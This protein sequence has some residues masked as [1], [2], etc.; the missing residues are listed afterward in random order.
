MIMGLK[1]TFFRSMSSFVVVPNLRRAAVLSLL[2]LGSLGFGG[3]AE[4]EIVEFQ[5]L[6]LNDV[7]EITPLSGGTEGGLARVATIRQALLEANPNTLTVLGG[8]FFSPS[9]LGTAKI[10]GDR[11]AGEQ[12]VNVL[13]HLGLDL[14]TFGN[15]EF[16]IKES[17][18]RARLTESK[19][20]WLSGNVLTAAGEP[21]DNVPPYFITTIS[22]ENDAEIRVGFVGVT[23]PS[24][25]AAYVSYLDPFTQMQ[26]YIDEIKADTD[27]IVG[28]THLAIADDQRL[29]EE[30]PEIDLILG[31]HE[32]ENIQQWRGKDFTPIFKAD[33]NA[34]TVY[35][36]KLAYDTE[37]KQ[38][39]INSQ[40]QVVNEAIAP[41]PFIAK[42]VNYW[43]QKAFDAF[44]DNGFDPAAIV[45]ESPIPLDGLESSVRN[46]PT[47][48]T[49]LIA[50][51]M[52][53]AAEDTELAIFNSGSI[54]VDDVLPPGTISQ[55]DVIRILPFG[56]DIVTVDMKGEVLEQALNQSLKNRGTGGYLQ[57]AAVSQDPDT[58]QWLIADIP[59][60]STK[61]YRVAV[62]DF[63]LSGKEV[64]LDFFSLDNPDIVSIANHG[65]VR[66]ALIEQLQQTNK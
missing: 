14:A 34:R 8:D 22:G 60:D 64:G 20:Q 52:L 42:V 15:H 13:N 47:D 38:L 41:D 49:D 37:L 45:T 56:G 59:L 58:Q 11:L 55:Y 7:Y 27:V 51:S 26:T 4:A 29:A 3:E 17:Q 10:N 24:N 54:R 65:D 23:L 12:M 43:Q 30:I 19:F 32:H 6:Q 61:T 21:W 31:G 25:P 39:T 16:D 33:A 36:H 62:N 18:F 44:R 2:L 35:I 57:T 5:L 1:L 9:A 53:A 63:L 48:L 66:F 46:Q 28:L 50:Q 40:L